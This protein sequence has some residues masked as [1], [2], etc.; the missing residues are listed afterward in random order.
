VKK[1][2]QFC[3]TNSIHIMAYSPIR[4]SDDVVLGNAERHHYETF[5]ADGGNDGRLLHL[6]NGKRYGKQQ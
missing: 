2:P 6:D 3:Y 5:D 4:Y 1:I